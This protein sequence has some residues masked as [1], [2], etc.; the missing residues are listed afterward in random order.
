MHFSEVA[1]LMNLGVHGTGWMTYCGHV[2]GF[3]LKSV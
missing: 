3:Q 1:P 2:S